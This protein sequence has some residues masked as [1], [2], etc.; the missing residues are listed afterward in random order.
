MDYPFWGA[1]YNIALEPCATLPGLSEAVS[2]N[3]SLKLGPGESLSAQMVAS[4]F[5]GESS[6]IS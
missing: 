5:E 2:R 1:T 4:V 3:E 6:F